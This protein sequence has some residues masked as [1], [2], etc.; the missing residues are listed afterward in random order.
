MGH[1]SFIS[2]RFDFSLGNFLK[3]ELQYQIILKCIF[4]VQFARSYSG[5][6]FFLIKSKLGC[7]VGFGELYVGRN[8]YNIMSINTTLE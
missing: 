1:E 8:I 5:T 7:G 4:Q 2:E 3:F 6:R